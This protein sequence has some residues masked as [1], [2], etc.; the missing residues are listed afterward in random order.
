VNA[1]ELIGKSEG[2]HL[3][4]KAAEALK[5]PSKIAREVVAMLN[6]SSG[7]DLG[8]IWIG[9]GECD[10]VA[11]DPHGVPDADKERA[12]LRDLLV[13]TIEPRPTSQEVN[14]AT[15]NYAPDVRLLRVSVRATR[16]R[17]PFALLKD[18]GRQYLTRVQDRI[19]PMTFDELREHWAERGAGGKEVVDV[20]TKWLLQQ[21]QAELAAPGAARLWIGLA[22]T[23]ELELDLES[24]ENHQ[25]LTDPAATRNRGHGWTFLGLGR[26]LRPMHGGLGTS[27]G[28]SSVLRVLRKGRIETQVPLEWL[29][30]TGDGVSR[31]ERELN[32][33]A[34][35]EYPTSIIR[36][37]AA[38]S[39]F[40]PAT[41]Y[42][43]ALA[44][45]RARGWKLW[46]FTPGAVA[47]RARDDSRYACGEYDDADDLILE[48]LEFSNDEL[49]SAPD[50]CA[51]RLLQRVYEA[52]HLG[53]DN[54]PRQFDPVTKRLQLD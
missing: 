32:P 40:S 29:Q 52:F 48:P 35:V 14:V 12:R 30:Y 41:G 24:T 18:G 53:P 43:V 19:A 5:K 26:Q 45:A 17:K 23:P 28:Q 46:P 15:E 44:M 7:Q 37:A 2:Q 49:T 51:Y 42:R 11:T 38:M 34:L 10:A 21:R 22:P 36:L 33:V 9:V 13:D 3:E 4:F 54:M 25:L 20:A 6:A 27:T 8:E 39:R 16:E 1:R 31:E 50:G 47:W